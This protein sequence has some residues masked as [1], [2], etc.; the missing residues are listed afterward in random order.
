MSRCST[1]RGTNV[2]AATLNRRLDLV[3]PQEV[4]DGAGG[5]TTT[6]T[7]LGTMWG[8]VEP[9]AGRSVSGEVGAVSVAGFTVLVRAA[10]VGQSNRPVVGQRFQFGG[11]VLRIDAVTEDEPGGRYLRC[12]C[13]EEVSA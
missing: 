11:R 13:T 9:R 3:S 10:P 12:A 8:R 5:C 2:A 4:S 6:W 1:S 7:V